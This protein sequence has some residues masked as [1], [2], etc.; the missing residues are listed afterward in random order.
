MPEYALIQN[1]GRLACL[2]CHLLFFRRF[3]SHFVELGLYIVYHLILPTTKNRRCKTRY[4][5]FHIKVT[6]P[7]GYSTSNKTK[8]ILISCYMCW[9]LLCYRHGIFQ[10]ILLIFNI[11]RISQSNNSRVYTTSL[12]LALAWLWPGQGRCGAFTSLHYFF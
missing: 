6:P 7:Q 10:N 9:R 2:L 8:L 3:S 12:G 5:L 11:N 4:G 1:I